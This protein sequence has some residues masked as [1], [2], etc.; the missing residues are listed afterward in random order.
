MVQMVVQGF[1]PNEVTL[2]ILSQVV[3]N[4]SMKRFPKVAKVLDWVISNDF[5]KETDQKTIAG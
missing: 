3:S 1:Q 4:G 5:Q 2:G